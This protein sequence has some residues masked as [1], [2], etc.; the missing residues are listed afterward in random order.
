MTH[1]PASEFQVA[2]EFF[3]PHQADAGLDVARHEGGIGGTGRGGTVEVDDFAEG[4][5]ESQ[6]DMRERPCGDEARLGGWEMKLG[7]VERRVSC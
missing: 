7:R 6:F 2:G 4:A 1:G 5:V 3:G